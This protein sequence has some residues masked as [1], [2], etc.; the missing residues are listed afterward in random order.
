[1]AISTPAQKPRGAARRTRSTS[2]ASRLPADLPYPGRMSLPRVVAVAPGSPAFR[3][4]LQPGDEVVSLAGRRP[5]DV[6]EWRLLADEA[7][8]D[9]ELRRGG[10]ELD[11]LVAKA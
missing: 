5:R 4:G 9:M 10:I 3:A 1:M 2:I 8:V 6:I 7:D 11:L